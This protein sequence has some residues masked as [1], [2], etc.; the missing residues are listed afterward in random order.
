MTTLTKDQWTAIEKQLAGYFGRVE[1]RCDGYLVTAAIEPIGKLK[2]GIVVYVN[3]WVKGEWMI[4]EAEEAKKFHREMKRYLYS[5]SKRAEARTKLKSRRL[6][7][8]LRGWYAG[9][10]EKYITTW[11]PYWTDARAFTRHLRKTCT[12]I[13]LISTEYRV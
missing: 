1:L 4:G 9:V 13:E 11:S 10:A 5:A 2:Q 8:E 6:H 3:G 7:A 12:E